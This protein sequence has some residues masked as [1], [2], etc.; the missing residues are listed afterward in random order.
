MRRNI[1]IKGFS[2]FIFVFIPYS[3]ALNRQKNLI[4]TKEKYLEERRKIKIDTNI[5]LFSLLL[6]LDLN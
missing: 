3:A 4:E 6:F 2:C 5:K 1:K